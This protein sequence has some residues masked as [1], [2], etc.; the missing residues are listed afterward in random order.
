MKCGQVQLFQ[1][2]TLPHFI[3]SSSK[4]WNMEMSINYL[5][6][7]PWLQIAFSQLIPALLATSPHWAWTTHDREFSSTI[8]LRSNILQNLRVLNSSTSKM[9]RSCLKFF[10]YESDVHDWS[11]LQKKL[12]LGNE[13]W[14]K[15]LNNLSA[16]KMKKIRKGK[17]LIVQKNW[18]R[19]NRNQEMKID[20]CLFDVK[21][22]AIRRW[23]ELEQI[24]FVADGI[25]NDSFY[26]C[27]MAAKCF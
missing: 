6:P 3:R 5:M 15:R 16:E 22:E 13:N 17:R 11:V 10:R 21:W 25:K 27:Y 4:E 1:W 12:K 24:Q 19:F 8:L 20:P 23:K 7:Q 2:P 26:N 9:D 18:M 14:K